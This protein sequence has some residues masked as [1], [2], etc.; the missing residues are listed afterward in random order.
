LRQK[1]I[2]LMVI[3]AV[4]VLAA[5][6]SMNRYVTKI[7]MSQPHSYTETL[8]F[9]DDG[10]YRTVHLEIDLDFSEGQAAFI[11]TDPNG[12]E[13][14]SDTIGGKQKIRNKY[15]P[16]LGTWTLDITVTDAVGSIEAAWRAVR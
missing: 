11:A 12:Q 9:E 5:A 16:V 14:W 7:H 6:C 1:I 3:A 2:A 13:L 15:E 8:S 4:L 10:N